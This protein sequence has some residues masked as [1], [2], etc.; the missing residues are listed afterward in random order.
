MGYEALGEV[1]AEVDADVDGDV[2]AEVDGEVEADVDGELDGEVDTDVD[3]EVETDVDGE[4]DGELE[5]S[6]RT[7]CVPMSVSIV[8]VYL[9]VSLLYAELNVAR[10]SKT[11]FAGRSA[12]A[13]LLYFV[14]MHSMIAN[15]ILRM[16][17]LEASA[18]AAVNSLN[19]AS[20]TVMLTPSSDQFAIQVVGVLSNM[21][22][23][24]YG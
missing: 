11:I 22:L 13:K 17:P 8:I 10:L 7:S 19:D 14:Q 5:T 16:S 2:D 6:S 3:G 20:G 21:C 12:A 18:S 1:D 24:P 15:T 9:F 4:L 23:F